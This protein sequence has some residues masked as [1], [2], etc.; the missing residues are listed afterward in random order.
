[1]KNRTLIGLLC[2]ILAVLVT[3][4]VSPV[5]NK[6]SEG[7]TDAV[8][9]TKDISQGAQISDKDIEIAKLTRSSLPQGF[10]AKKADVVGK[11]AN[12]DLFQGDVA[13][14]K[15]LTT[16]ANNTVNVLNALTGS[17]VAMSITIKSFANGLSAKLMGGDIIS[18]YV[19]DKDNKT[20]VPATLK[21][22]KVITTTTAGG[23]DET[24]VVENEDGT[25]ALPTTVTVLVTVKQ[26][27]QLANFEKNATMHVA[28]VYRGAEKTANK[29]IARQDKY[30]K[31]LETEEKANG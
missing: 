11:F 21:Y 9:F 22:V 5:G 17:K 6:M 28:L 2:I 7:K 3:F 8:R 20:T 1:L 19:T 18:I 31:E 25:K 30:L 29:F 23:V 10:F 15:K 16:D 24:D 13:T 26:A 14:A 12:A 27:Q 4:V